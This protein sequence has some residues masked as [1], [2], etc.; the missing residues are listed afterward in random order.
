MKNNTHLHSPDSNKAN[1]A[2]GA[3]SVFN[4]LAGFYGFDRANAWFDTQ[5]ATELLHSVSLLFP[6]L[7]F[8]FVRRFIVC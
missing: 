3:V 5:Q 7:L 2:C 8:A 6:M 1:I 4:I